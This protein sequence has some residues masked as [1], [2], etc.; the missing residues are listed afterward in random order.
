MKTHYNLQSIIVGV[1]YFEPLPCKRRNNG[2]SEKRAQNIVP[3][4]F[5]RWIFLQFCIFAFLPTFAQ[6][7]GGTFTDPRDG[8]TYKTV[9]MPDGKRWMAENLRYRKGLDNPVFANNATTNANIVGK[10]YCPGP[11]PLNT[12]VNQAD[13]LACEYWGCLY[14]FWTANA[15]TNGT[16]SLNTLVGKQ[17]ICPPNWHLPSDY[18]WGR[19]LDAVEKSYNPAISLTGTNTHISAATVRTAYGNQAGRVLKDT[20][21]RSAFVNNQAYTPTWIGTPSVDFNN[22][23]FSVKAAGIRTTEGNYVNCGGAAYFW[24]SNNSVTANYA[25]SRAFGLSENTIYREIRQNADALSVR[26]VEGDCKITDA[27][28]LGTNTQTCNQ[29]DTIYFV[30]GGPAFPQTFVLS[31]PPINGTWTFGSVNVSGIPAGVTITSSSI[32]ASRQFTL[33]FSNLTMAA[34]DQIINVKIV[35]TNPQHCDIEQ[36]FTIR[37][38]GRT[39]SCPYKGQDLYEDATHICQQRTSGANNWEAWIKDCR[40]GEFYR[41]VQFPN[42]DWW[43]ADNLRWVSPSNISSNSCIVGNCYFGRRY[44]SWLAGAAASANAVS[45]IQGVC[46]IGWLIP[47]P[48]QAGNLAKCAGGNCNSPSVPGGT[49]IAQ[50]LSSIN[51]Q[52]RFDTDGARCTS[53]NNFWGFAWDNVHVAGPHFDQF[54]NTQFC[55]GGYF[56]KDCA[57]STVAIS[58]ASI[59]GVIR[60]IRP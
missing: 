52:Q 1:Q 59:S 26:C 11:G 51:G 35:A 6:T 48:T 22:Y 34:N 53:A 4:R 30:D 3:L 14:P 49:A 27:L 13:P 44:G 17:G 5:A 57:G 19:M 21:K 9:I 15:V 50:A 54:C 16:G 38:I 29:S 2:N 28:S 31:T 41:I 20:V 60:C 45:S 40:D 46:P 55:G 58:N 37:L 42:G 8:Q 18:E 10:Y 7:D 39:T 25:I 47:S 24:T 56:S 23:N 33:T 12:S 36:T 32:D 43:F